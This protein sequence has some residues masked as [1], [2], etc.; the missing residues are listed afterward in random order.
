[1]AWQRDRSNSALVFELKRVLH[2]LKGGA[3]MAGIRAM[4]DLSHELESL[5]ELIEAGQVEAS[6][7]VF[8][9]LQGSLDELHRMR[10]TVNHGGRCKQARELLAQIRALSGK[11][12]AAP[13]PVESVPTAAVAPPVA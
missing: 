6:E 4:G 10:D 8:G 3:R 5:M 2:T 12:D 9:A 1:S 11:Q 13:P 7:A